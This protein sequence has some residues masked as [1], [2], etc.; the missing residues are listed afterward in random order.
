MSFD[1]DSKL[2]KFI[3]YMKTHAPPAGSIFG[4]DPED[5]GHKDDTYFDDA[6]LYWRPTP[7]PACGHEWKWQQLLF[8]SVEYCEKCG[9]RKDEI[10]R[11]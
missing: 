7:K 11:S 4:V 5:P 6:A 10:E 8:S 9:K 3:E 1:L 2:A